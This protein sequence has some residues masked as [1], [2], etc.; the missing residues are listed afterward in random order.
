MWVYLFKNGLMCR[1]FGD[2]YGTRQGWR[3]R[4]K[5][6]RIVEFSVDPQMNDEGPL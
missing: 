2:T 5:V 1:W 4:R 6:S 3:K